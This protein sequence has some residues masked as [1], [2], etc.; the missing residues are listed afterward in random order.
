MARVSI[1]HAVVL[2]L[3]LFGAACT[4]DPA[5]EPNEYVIALKGVTDDHLAPCEGLGEAPENQVGGLLTDY[6]N[7]AGVAGTCRA[8]HNSLA[9]YIR[10]LVE[11]ARQTK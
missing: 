7:L 9:D 2:G 8:R 3:A 10:P 5:L 4:T 6:N 1:R 11:K